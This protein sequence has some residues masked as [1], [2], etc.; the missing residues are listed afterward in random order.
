MQ[1]TQ[2]VTAGSFPT[3]KMALRSACCN[4]RYKLKGFVYYKL[5]EVPGV[6]RK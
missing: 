3:Q 6:T 2:F 4:V 1:K 5:A